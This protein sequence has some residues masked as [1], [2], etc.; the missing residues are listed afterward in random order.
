MLVRERPPLDR[1]GMLPNQVFRAAG[2]CFERDLSKWR[3]RGAV[4]C[5]LW[6]QRLLEGACRDSWCAQYALGVPRFV[7]FIPERRE[8]EQHVSMLGGICGTNNCI[9][10]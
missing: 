3:S 2:D 6:E 9:R 7:A 4:S 5:V 8:D 1:P 10:R